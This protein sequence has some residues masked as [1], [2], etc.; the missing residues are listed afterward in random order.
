MPFAFG[1]AHNAVPRSDGHMRPQASHFAEQWLHEHLNK[2]PSGPVSA[3]ELADQL[4][5]AGQMAGIPADEME[6]DIGSVFDLIFAALEH[7]RIEA[8]KAVE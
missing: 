1:N 3:R 6:D 7:Q 8:K 5:A 2:T 4:I